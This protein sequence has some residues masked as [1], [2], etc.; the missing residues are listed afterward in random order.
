[1]EEFYDRKNVKEQVILRAFCMALQWLTLVLGHKS[2]FY[3]HV[4]E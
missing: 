3:F 1:M 4:N 2:A